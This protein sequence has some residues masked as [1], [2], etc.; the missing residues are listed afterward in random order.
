MVIID[1]ATPD[2]IEVDLLPR[3]ARTPAARQEQAAR[4]EMPPNPYECAPSTRLDR[5]RSLRTLSGA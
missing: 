4:P 1:R 3:A 2:E 5:R